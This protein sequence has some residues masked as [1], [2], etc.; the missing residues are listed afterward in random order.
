MEIIHEIHNILF[1][2]DIEGRTSGAVLKN[3]P[4][5]QA[6][7]HSFV[8][9]SLWPSSVSPGRKAKGSGG[10]GW[11]PWPREAQSFSCETQYP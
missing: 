6:R 1:K 4:K 8:S 2:Q 7:V 5:A 9:A 11:F 3:D 10:G